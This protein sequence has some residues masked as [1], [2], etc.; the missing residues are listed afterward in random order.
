[1]ESAKQGQRN[2]TFY[3]LV[4]LLSMLADLICQNEVMDPCE[5]KLV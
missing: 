5:P 3:R 4:F 1:M 2:A